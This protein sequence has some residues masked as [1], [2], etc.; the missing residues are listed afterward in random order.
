MIDTIFSPANEEI[1]REGF[2]KKFLLEIADELG[3]SD[4]ELMYRARQMDLRKYCE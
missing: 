1:L 3:C 2:G 4:V